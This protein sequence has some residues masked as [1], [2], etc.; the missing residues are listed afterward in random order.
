MVC[1]PIE[2]E[3]SMENRSSHCHDSETATML[4]CK[5]SGTAVAG[6]GQS[7]Y[8]RKCFREPDRAPAHSCTPLRNPVKPVE[9]TNAPL[10]LSAVYCCCYGQEAK[11]KVKRATTEQ[12]KWPTTLQPKLEREIC[13]PL[14]TMGILACTIPVVFIKVGWQRLCGVHDM[15]A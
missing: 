11:L 6:W 8:T 4:R 5:S 2:R 15:T 9:S 3:G 13:L 10:L 12:V 7:S 1:L 14:S